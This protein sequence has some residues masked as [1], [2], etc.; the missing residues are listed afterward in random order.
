MTWHRMY[1]WE[2]QWWESEGREHASMKPDNDYHDDNDDDDSGDEDDEDDEDDGDDEDD[3][4]GKCKK[5]RGE[6]QVNIRRGRAP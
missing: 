6:W 4:D 2:G 1:R 3:E 5:V